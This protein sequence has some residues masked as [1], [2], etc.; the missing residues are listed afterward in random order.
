MY[1]Y[2]VSESKATHVLNMTLSSINNLSQIAT[3]VRVKTSS[4]TLRK[5]KKGSGYNETNSQNP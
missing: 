3:F 4:F 1:L 2:L 5:G